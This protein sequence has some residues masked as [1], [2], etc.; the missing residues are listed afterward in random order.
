MEELIKLIKNDPT[1]KVIFLHMYIN[2]EVGLG[3]YK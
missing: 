2:N 3:F 1:I